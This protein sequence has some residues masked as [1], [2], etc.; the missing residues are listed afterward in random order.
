[1]IRLTPLTVTFVA[2]DGF[3]PYDKQE[4]HKM[5][6]KLLYYSTSINAKVEPFPS[7]PVIMALLL[8]QHKL[9]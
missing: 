5:L 6:E 8:E 7:E 1:L 3:P 9:I 4:F 2:E